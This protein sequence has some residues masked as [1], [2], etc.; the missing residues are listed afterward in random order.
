[1]NVSAKLIGTK[2]EVGALVSDR[3]G[4]RERVMAT[5]GCV[6][7]G[8]GLARGKVTASSNGMIMVKNH[9]DR[10]GCRF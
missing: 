8:T 1:M 6:P 9:I 10:G 7:R 5:V 2:G 3:I 4:A